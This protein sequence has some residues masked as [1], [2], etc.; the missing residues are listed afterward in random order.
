MGGIKMNKLITLLSGLLVLTLISGIGAAAEIFVYPGESIQKSINSANPGDIIV[1][2]PG[3]YIEN[4][5]VSKDRLTIKSESGN[6]DDTIIKAKSSSSDVFYLQADNT[7][8]RG[9]KISGATGSGHAGIFLHYNSQCKIENNELLDNACGI[10]LWYSTKNI[11]SKNKANNNGASG[12]IL[13][14]NADSNTLLGNTISN[15]QRGIYFAT[16]HDNTLSSNFIQ[17]NGKLGLFVCGKSKRNLIY[18]NYFN[19]NKITVQTGVGN[20]YNIEK[21]EGTNIVGGPYIGGNY[22]ANLDGTGFSQKAVDKNEDGISD[23]AYTR[24][25]GSKCSDLLP[26]VIPSKPPEKVDHPVANFWGSPRSGNVPLNVKFTDISKGKPRAWKWSFGDGTYSTQQNPAHKY[27]KAGKYTVSL[28]VSNAEGSN[29]VT[30]SNYIVATAL[31]QPVASFVMSKASGKAPLQVYFTDKSTGTISS[32]KWSFGDGTTS[33]V[34][35]PSHKFT[36]A[37]KFKVVFT[38]SNKA[39]SSSK[40]QYVTI[41]K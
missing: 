34:K 27:N 14:A 36:K 2:K 41:T 23:S 32:V 38:V 18:N 31:K 30:K 15:N 20:A 25:S 10:C 7:V 37:G 4:I 11:V 12:G 33:T 17:K 1:V 21:T 26:L 39:G 8:I 6:P 16:S 19:E 40:S 28:A 5:K 22:W 29:T 35:S 13:F 9:F 3:T 24:I